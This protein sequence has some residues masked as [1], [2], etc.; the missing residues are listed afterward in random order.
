MAEGRRQSRFPA[1]APQGLL[2]TLTSFVR[3]GRGMAPGMR[4]P[5][6][7]NMVGVPVILSFLAVFL[8]LGDGAG[9][10]IFLAARACRRLFHPVVP[11]W[12]RGRR[13]TRF[14]FDFFTESSDRMG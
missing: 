14:A 3:C 1:A 11:A 8:V 6:A 7:K 5:S 4:S 10:A 13:N 2:P 9:V 12:A